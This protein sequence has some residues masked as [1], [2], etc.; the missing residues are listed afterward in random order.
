MDFKEYFQNRSLVKIPNT[1]IHFEQK[2]TPDLIWCVSHVVLNLI[3]NNTGKIFTDKDVRE[4]ELFNSLMRDYFSKAPQENAENEYNKVSSYQ[5]GVLAFA[6]I[7]EQISGRPKKY[8]V[9]NIDALK[10]IAV[11]DFNAANFLCE[12]TEKLIL[13][14]GLSDFFENYKRNPNQ[15]NY[16]R[17]KEAYWNWAK[18]HT[19]IKGDDKR[20]TYRVFNKIFNVYC[21]K[22]RIPGEDGS[23]I[24]EGPCPYSFLIYNRTNFR[25]KDM[26]AGMTR[27]QYHEQVLSDIE[28]GGVV[29]TL[30]QKVKDTVKAQH[31]NDSEIKDPSYGYSVNSGVHVHHILPR[32]SY[33]Q[34]SLT[35]ENLISLTP[36]Q[37]LSLAHV[38]A[39]TK[40]IS[41]TF[42]IICLKKKF[43][44]IS[45]SINENNNFYD[46]KEFIKVINTCFNWDLSENSTI[47][48]V[49]NKLSAL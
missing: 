31:G 43:E 14:N 40:V 26:P 28:Q 23:N 22:H 13:D 39:N 27:Q 21:Y 29:E 7:L 48:Q 9:A 44:Q 30:L 8:R 46:L 4:S 42:Q 19:A 3:E 32:N 16:L 20:H 10:F 33:P 45:K 5:L 36:G 49:E 2:I 11:N 6:G 41:P 34:F 15:E 38:E 37:H 35:K 1:G 18:T 17:V 47:M 25:D 24:T 12:Y